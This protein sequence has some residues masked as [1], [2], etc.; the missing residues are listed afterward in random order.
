MFVVYC[1]AHRAAVLLSASQ[2]D[3]IHRSPGGE[4]GVEIE[5]RCWCG[6]QG[7]TTSGGTADAAN[8]PEA[9]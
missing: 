3:A 5:W 6:H 1:P 4:R 8:L 9:S 2:I 7:R